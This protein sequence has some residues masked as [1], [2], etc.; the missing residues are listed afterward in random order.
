[1]QRRRGT[2]VDQ[3]KLAYFTLQP[4]RIRVGDSSCRGRARGGLQGETADHDENKKETD[5]DPGIS[6]IQRRAAK[7]IRKA[8]HPN[9]AIK[10][11]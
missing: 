8:G 7:R 1:M 6:Q 4:R 11:G 2:Q 10:A 9:P 5:H 3:F